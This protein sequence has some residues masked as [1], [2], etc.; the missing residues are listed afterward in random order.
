MCGLTQIMPIKRFVCDA[1]SQAAP[2]GECF[3]LHIVFSQ[4]SPMASGR[5]RVAWIGVQSEARPAQMEMDLVVGPLRGDGPQVR[6]METTGQGLWSERKDR[7]A[8]GGNIAPGEELSD[9][10]ARRREA[11][12]RKM[13]ARELRGWDSLDVGLGAET[14]RPA[15]NRRTT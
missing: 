13:H 11:G 4:G 10:K 1:R 3:Y 14:R 8:G 12:G 15:P 5:L 7:G 9:A 6:G 2:N